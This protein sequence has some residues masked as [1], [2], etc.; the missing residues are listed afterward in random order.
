MTSLGMITFFLRRVADFSLEYNGVASF[1]TFNTLPY[2]WKISPFI[3][4]TT[5]FWRLAFFAQSVFHVSFTLTIATMV[6]FSLD[7]GEYGSFA[8]VDE[9]N[10]AVAKSGI[11]LVAYYSVKLGYLLGLSK[12]TLTSVKIV[13]YVGFMVDSSRETFHLIPEKKG[14]FVALMSPSKR[15]STL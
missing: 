6:S 3:Y 7:K 9:R 10:R 5:A 2:G 14:K 4:H 15:Y 8:T 13:P 12:S 1:F 11:F